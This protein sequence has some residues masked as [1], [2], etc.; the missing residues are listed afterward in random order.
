MYRYYSIHTC[1]TIYSHTM[2]IISIYQI[3][4]STLCFHIGIFKAQYNIILVQGDLF[5]VHTFFQNTLRNCFYIILSLHK[6][7]YL[8]NVVGICNLAIAKVIIFRV[9]FFLIYI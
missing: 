7:T 6:T 9:F 5:N 3:T 2:F 1:I 4:Y 8:G